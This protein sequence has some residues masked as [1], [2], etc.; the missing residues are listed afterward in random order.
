MGRFL[1]PLIM[2][3]LG[4][5][6][7]VEHEAITDTLTALYPVDAARRTALQHCFKE[8]RFFNRFSAKARI[9]CYE[10]YLATSEAR[11]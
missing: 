8:D 4:I 1:F 6:G 7:L 5:F 10:K 2:I 9:A 11:P 3:G